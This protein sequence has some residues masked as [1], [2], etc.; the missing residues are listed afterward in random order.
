MRA[1]VSVFKNATRWPTWNLGVVTV[2]GPLLD[3]VCGF[4]GEF[5]GCEYGIIILL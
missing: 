1:R 2:L 4:L 3:E 5:C